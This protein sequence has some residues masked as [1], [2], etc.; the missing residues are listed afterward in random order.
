MISST[1]PLVEMHI[2]G[3][4][5]IPAAFGRV[6][7][8]GRGL[9]SVP[10]LR[11]AKVLGT[12]SGRSFTMR[13]ADLRHW[14][15]LTVWDDTATPCD[16]LH[17]WH[18]AADEHLTVAM[19]PLAARGHWSRR[20]PFGVLGP[21]GR[22]SKHA[23][24]VAAITRARLRTRTMLSFWRAVPPVAE[25]LARSPGVRLALGIG[26][27]PVGLQG[28]FSLWNDAQALTDFA[29]RSPAHR[30]AIRRTATE[31]WYTEELFAR[32]HIESVAGT[33]RGVTP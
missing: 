21:A 12:G 24:P 13:D 4:T 26:E 32:F 27:S 18:E 7:A 22:S 31:Q 29:Y 30:S 8:A 3:V 1:P 19:R 11:F 25:T 6:A 2:F 10:G 17:R 5:S 16:Y 20:E 33:Y 9:R 14:A 15:V 23:G 28:T